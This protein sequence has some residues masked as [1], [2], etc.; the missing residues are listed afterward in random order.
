MQ[1]HGDSGRVE[2]FIPRRTPSATIYRYA[3][4]SHNGGYRGEKSDSLWLCFR[5]YVPR[6]PRLS[7]TL[8]NYTW[9]DEGVAECTAD[10]KNPLKQPWSIYEVHLG[11]WQRDENGKL[12]QLSRN[13]AH[14][15]AAYAK[16]MGYTHL[17]NHA[18]HGISC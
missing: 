12:A 9:D 16:E 8:I 2:L 15:L 1:V 3:I 6:M 7:R 10:K 11:S 17:E 5:N 4:R 13:L 14:R 18:D